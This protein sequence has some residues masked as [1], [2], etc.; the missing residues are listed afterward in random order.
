[1]ISDLA[2][3][4]GMGGEFSMHPHSFRHYFATRYYRHTGDLALTQDML[5]HADP[6]TTR[7]YAETSDE[8]REQA[9]KELFDNE[10]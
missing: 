4:T 9:H 2:D 3:R 7:I 5:G 10:G 8:A 6:A 1:M